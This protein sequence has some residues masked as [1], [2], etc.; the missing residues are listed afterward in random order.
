MTQAEGMLRGVT[1]TRDLSSWTTPV[2]FAL[3][4]CS[5]FCSLLYQVVWLR[6]AFAR[7]GVITPVL[8]VVLSVFMLGLGVGSV[9][10]GR[11]AERARRLG[12]SPAHL[13][14]G[15]ELTVGIGAFLV[16]L[17]LD[18]GADFLLK[19]GEASS[20]GYLFWSA[21]F[22]RMTVRPALE[23]SSATTLWIRAH[24]SLWAPGGVS[25]RI[26]QSP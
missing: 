4:F 3:F 16:P 26:C 1:K 7:F 22:K 17:F 13:Y 10:G 19:A 20:S 8:S 21:V 12:V 5:G 9:F 11:W 25:Q 2:L 14:G 23:R 24:C 6:M 15:A 18:A